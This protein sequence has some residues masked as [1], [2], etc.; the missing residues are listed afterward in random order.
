MYL[1]RCTL[2]ISEAPCNSLGHMTVFQITGLRSWDTWL[3]RPRNGPLT[4]LQCIQHAHIPQTEIRAFGTF[5]IATYLCQYI[6]PMSPQLMKYTNTRDLMWR[7]WNRVQLSKWRH[8]FRELPQTTLAWLSQPLR[9]IAGG[10]RP[11][12]STISTT[13][14]NNLRE[15]DWLQHLSLQWSSMQRRCAEVEIYI[16]IDII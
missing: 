7:Y 13:Q 11:S 16:D 3:N 9:R 10:R 4:N 6:S 15:Q 14:K 1:L 2:E 5:Y 8:T 12:Y